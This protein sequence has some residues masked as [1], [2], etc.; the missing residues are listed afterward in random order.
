MAR[1]PHA[2]NDA[3]INF[4][5]QQVLTLRGRNRRGIVSTK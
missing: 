3:D 4:Y 5:F 2:M 1:G